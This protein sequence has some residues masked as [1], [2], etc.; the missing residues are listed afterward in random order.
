MKIKKKVIDRSLVTNFRLR[1]SS[2]L[3][4]ILNE[5]FS[6]SEFFSGDKQVFINVLKVDMDGNMMGAKVFVDTFGLEPRDQLS[7]VK[8][9]NNDFAGQ[10]RTI[11]AEKIRA[12]IVP[13]LQFYHM[14]D[15]GRENRVLELI[16]K[17]GQS[18]DD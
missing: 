11:L 13:K 15:L 7:L 14:G 5:I 6:R 4:D 18:S 10:I 8:K 16:E 1:R 9:L 3:R 2:R 12:K 17:C